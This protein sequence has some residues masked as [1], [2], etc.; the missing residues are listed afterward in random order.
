MKNELT[1]VNELRHITD[2]KNNI[3]ETIRLLTESQTRIALRLYYSG[4]ESCAPGHFF[5]PAVRTHYL[6]HFIRSGKGRY[7]RGNSEYALKKGDAFL[8]L[9]G[10]TTKYMADEEE[11]WEYTW[12]AFDGPDGRCCVTVVLRI[13][14][15]STG[16]RTRRVHSGCLHRQLCL[17]TVFTKIARTC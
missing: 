10:E 7:M 3:R 1:Q 17:R 6:I 12:I 16:H 15:L 9:P 2:E 4:S 11:P 5:G 13:P 8:I 14:R